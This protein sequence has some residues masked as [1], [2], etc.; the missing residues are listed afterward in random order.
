MT[1][2]FRRAGR[3]LT[4]SGVLAVRRCITCRSA[5]MRAYLRRAAYSGD[6]PS[7]RCSVRRGRR[8]RPGGFHDGI[9]A[10]RTAGC[11]GW[12]LLG[13]VS[14]FSGI[15]IG[16]KATRD[17]SRLDGRGQGKPLPG[18]PRQSRRPRDAQLRNRGGWRLYAGAGYRRT[19]RNF[20]AGRRGG[21][22]LSRC[23]GSGSSARVRCFAIR[24]NASA[25]PQAYIVASSVALTPTRIG[26][27][28]CLSIASGR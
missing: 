1:S 28:R 2:Y 4:I 5:M 24:P 12:R 8:P 23:Q 15:R 26:L 13:T 9:H 25:L 27:Q 21:R 6:T 17:H 3:T 18:S 14:G 10:P 11:G 19:S 22:L 20:W 16:H 7:S